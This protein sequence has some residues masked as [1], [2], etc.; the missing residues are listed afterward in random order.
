[1]QTR[2][3]TGDNDRV[4]AA[5]V[6]WRRNHALQQCLVD[7][8]SCPGRVIRA[9]SVQRA[10]IMEY[11][12]RAGHVYMFQTT[13]QG[14]QLSLVGHRTATTFTG[15]CAEHDLHL[16]REVD[17]DNSRS[18]DLASPRQ[19]VLLALRAAA[20]EYWLK[21]NNQKLYQ[22]LV[23]LGNRADYESLMRMLN[24]ENA[25]AVRLTLTL[26]E[27]WKPSLL[28]TKVS[29]RRIQRLFRSLYQQAQTGSFHL[30]RTALFQ[31]PG[32]PTVA[33]ASAFAPEFDLT[34]KQ[35]NTL[36][37]AVCRREASVET[38]TAC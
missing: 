34:G 3:T 36:R 7:G 14:H 1:M 27:K 37:L 32:S 11:L 25:D 15:F 20:R 4:F 33:A 31:I 28:G 29:L 9:H 17:F 10:H 6:K 16:F 12:A 30:T 35:L 21:L 38:P 18:F 22:Q 23:E 19:V 5:I 8:A 2:H 26:E 13:G 24:L